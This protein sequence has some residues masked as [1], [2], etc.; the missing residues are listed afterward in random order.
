M[1]ESN[2]GIKTLACYHPIEPLYPHRTPYPISTEL[3]FP[4]WLVV[5]IPLNLESKI[6]TILK[7]C[8]IILRN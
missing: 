2:I 3:K 6:L 4:D 1:S 7:Y 8:N 5:V